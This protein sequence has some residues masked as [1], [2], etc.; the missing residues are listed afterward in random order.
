MVKGSYLGTEEWEIFT[1]HFIYLCHG[2]ELIFTM[3]KSKL[4]KT[5]LAQWKV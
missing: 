4:V 3:Y 1:F 5:R 2:H